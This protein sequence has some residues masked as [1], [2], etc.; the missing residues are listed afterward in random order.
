MH[1][2]S[3]L[4]LIAFCATPSL[5]SEPTGSHART[6]RHGLSASET[7]QPNGEV[8]YRRKC[9]ACHQAE[10]QGLPNW[11]P[12]LS[13]S[14]LLTAEPQDVSYLLLHGKDGMPAFHL[15]LSDEVIA[16]I[17]TYA[18]GAWGN[19]A[20][21]VTA[22]VVAEERRKLGSDGIVIPHN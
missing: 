11:I 14:P 12:Q 13:G 9:A 2:C 18:R 22:E 6:E 8:L 17:L 4:L 7:G 16:S 21:P 3:F 15:Y 19:G 5:A 1:R 20:G 10:G